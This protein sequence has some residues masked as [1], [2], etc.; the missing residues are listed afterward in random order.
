MCDGTWSP[1]EL[2]PNTAIL[3]GRAFVFDGA[4]VRHTLVAENG[5]M[6]PASLMRGAIN[7]VEDISLLFVYCVVERQYP[8]ERFELIVER[9]K[10]R[11]IKY[12]FDRQTFEECF[13]YTDTSHGERLVMTP[14]VDME[15]QVREVEVPLIEWLDQ[16]HPFRVTEPHDILNEYDASYARQRWAIERAVKR[17]TFVATLWSLMRAGFMSKTSCPVDGCTTG[18]WPILWGGK[19]QVPLSAKM[20]PWCERKHRRSRNAQNTQNHRQGRRHSSDM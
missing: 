20:C 12:E 18:P 8:W 5:E 11:A 7:L 4:T 15:G 19:G 13:Q 6:Y 14:Y 17:A 1:P 10:H 16:R 9:P 3:N 2:P